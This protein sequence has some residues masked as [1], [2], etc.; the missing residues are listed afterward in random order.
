VA[1]PIN[2]WHVLASDTAMAPDV[3]ELVR[4]C[5]VVRIGAA[6][7]NPPEP[8]SRILEWRRAAVP[9]SLAT[10]RP[11]RGPAARR[12]GLGRRRHRCATCPHHFRPLP[13]SHRTSCWAAAPG[14]Q[15]G[16]ASI[17][18]LF[19]VLPRYT[20]CCVC[21]SGMGW[22]AGWCMLRTHS[23]APHAHRLL[24]RS[25]LSCLLQ[26]SWPAVGR[27]HFRC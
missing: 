12:S 21:C 26:L 23:A 22:D 4:I 16:C 8:A 7:F 3:C 18:I 5:V 15:L 14:N 19:A 10:W 27:G 6:F 24:A 13:P 20:L 9:L 2:I 17:E 11:T 25:T 1:H